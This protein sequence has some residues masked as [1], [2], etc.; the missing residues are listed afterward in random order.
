[1][2]ARRFWGVALAFLAG[3]VIIVGWGET[4]SPTSHWLYPI[5]V[6]DEG[7]GPVVLRVRG[8]ADMI[9]PPNVRPGDA[10]DVESLGLVRR[11]RL[12]AGAPP[13]TTFTVR[14]RSDGV[15][16]THT[17]TAYHAPSRPFVQ[18]W[19]FL[20][21]VTVGGLI[22]GVVAFRRPSL[23]T[24]ALVFWSANAITSLGA[25][26]LFLW[27]PDPFFSIWAVLSLTIFTSWP[28]IALV[29]FITRF[30]RPADTRDARLRVAAGDALFWVYGCASLFEFLNEPLI[31]RSWPQF[32]TFMI[33]FSTIASVAFA[34]LAFAAVRGEDRRRIGWVIAGYVIASIGSLGFNLLDSIVYSTRSTSGESAWFVVAIS[35][36][37]L[38]EVAFPIA[39]A[40]AVLRY[41]VLDIG[42]VV[43]RAIVYAFVTATIVVVI[44]F[45]DWLSGKLISE[46]RIAVA[47]EAAVTIA[48]G[49]ALHAVHSRIEKFVDRFIFRARY[50]AERRMQSAID[51]LAFATSERAI[52]L[53]L[54]EEA[55]TIL[56]LRC[57]A[58]YRMSETSGDFRLCET[59]G[60]PEASASSLD[61]NSLLVRT[62]R[63]Q[64]RTL[65]I[66]DLG[67]VDPTLPAGEHGPTVAVPI[68]TQHTVLGIALYGNDREGASPDPEILGLL[69][70]LCSSAATAYSNVESRALR[71]QVIELQQRLEP[72]ALAA[73]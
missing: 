40:Y 53:A 26:T 11:I 64:E 25:A 5:S 3:L 6:A 27:L 39:L 69:G 63:A 34:A 15:W 8:P 65:F 66:A 61:E 20:F 55:T 18:T 56:S 42:F 19:A 12:E 73:E 67:V 30:P 48:F 4:F 52:D 9:V 2:D 51:A 17:L 38:A 37:V 21:D 16:S 72:R 10:V 36:A 59:V 60:W 23:A 44:S 46:S 1:M 41:R 58:V 70:R 32:D 14:I 24:A 57:A 13:G 71:L 7:A 43:N 47:A 29:P 54:V 35:T 49:V 50:V 68:A 62:V 28:A 45:V 31:L 33:Y 22:V